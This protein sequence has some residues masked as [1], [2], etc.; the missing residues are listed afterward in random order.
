MKTF[1]NTVFAILLIALTCCSKGPDIVES[2]ATCT[3]DGFRGLTAKE[4]TSGV[5]KYK[6][7][8]ADLIN[9]LESTRTHTEAFQDARTCWYSLD[10]LKKYICLIEKYSSDINLPS[11]RLG[12][13]FF[14]AVYPNTMNVGGQN[15]GNH[16]TLFMV[17]TYSNGN[18]NLN[19]DPRYSAQNRSDS[20]PSILNLPASTQLFILDAAAISQSSERQYLLKNQ[21]QICPPACPGTVATELNNIDRSPWN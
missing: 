16:H 9:P 10:T 6:Y 11:S 19:F 21:G 12:I 15:Y 14:Y 13:R 18:E 20:I 2:D 5:A 1:M 17:P 8:R 4:F 3:N 7:T